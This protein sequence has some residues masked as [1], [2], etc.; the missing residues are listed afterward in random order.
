MP[1]YVYENRLIKSLPTTRRPIEGTLHP[2]KDTFEYIEDKPNSTHHVL[3]WRLSTKKRH[4]RTS[5]RLVEVQRVRPDVFAGFFGKRSSRLSITLMCQEAHCI[6]CCVADLPPVCLAPYKTTN[7]ACMSSLFLAGATRLI[8]SLHAS[9]FERTRYS[10]NHTCLSIC[11]MHTH[12]MYFGLVQRLAPGRVKQMIESRNQERCRLDACFR[13]QLKPKANGCRK[14]QI[15]LED[16]KLSGIRV[17]KESYYKKRWRLDACFRSQLTPK[18]H[19]CHE[20]EIRLGDKWS[21]RTAAW[22]G[23]GKHAIHWNSLVCNVFRVRAL[24]ARY[25]L[26]GL[27]SWKEAHLHCML[28]PSTVLMF[29]SGIIESDGAQE[30]TQSN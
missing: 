28:S 24:A 12:C 16:K 14:S 13:S 9:M 29:L 6:L 22:L 18:A 20:S 26:I 23:N 11:C 1:L 7:L 30:D 8:S 10:C 2:V 15:R 21:S 17:R 5:G 27:L 4:D 3:M 25:R 19:S